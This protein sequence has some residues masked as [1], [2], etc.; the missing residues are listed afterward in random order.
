MKLI[1]TIILAT[2]I[3]LNSITSFANNEILNTRPYKASQIK[4][5]ANGGNCSHFA[6][7][8]FYQYYGIWFG[9]PD[10]QTKNWRQLR[11]KGFRVDNIDYKIKSTTEPRINSIMFIDNGN[12]VSHVAWVNSA[13]KDKN[14]VL[15]GVIESD[16]QGTLVHQYNDCKYRFNIYRNPKVTYIFAEKSN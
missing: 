1:M 7:E 5:A 13:I 11:S 16:T 14:G 6:E 12:G 10:N 9:F 2:I 8:I 3:S 4:V 15:I